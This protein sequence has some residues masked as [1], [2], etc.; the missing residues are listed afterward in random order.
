MDH[1]GVSKIE[2]EKRIGETPLRKTGENES[3]SD[4]DVWKV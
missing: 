1:F 4:D 3:S 2:A